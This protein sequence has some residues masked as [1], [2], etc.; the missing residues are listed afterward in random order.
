MIGDKKRNQMIHDQE[1][2]YADA[3]EKELRKKLRN[4]E[5]AQR[6]RDRQ[7]ARMQWLEHEVSLLQVRNLTLSRENALLRNVLA[8]GG[9]TFDSGNE[10]TS[11][12]DCTADE[13]KLAEVSRKQRKRSSE[14]GNGPEAK[15]RRVS[16]NQPEETNTQRSLSDSEVDNS[17]LQRSLITKTSSLLGQIMN[18]LLSA[19]QRSFDVFTNPGAGGLSSNEDTPDEEPTRPALL[20]PY[21]LPTF[22]LR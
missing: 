1:E 10:Q 16:A 5:S 13:D 12:S 15:R 6:A 21:L 14:A 20:F 9:K 17:T 11:P 3:D 18:P 8:L 2:G 7:K 4:R 22:P 19:R